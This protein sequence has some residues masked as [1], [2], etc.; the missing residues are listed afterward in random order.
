[1]SPT[2]RLKHLIRDIRPSLV[3]RL[4]Q[5]CLAR[6]QAFARLCALIAA[7]ATFLI[8]PATFALPSDP[9]QAINIESDRVQRNDKTGLTVY[10]GTVHMIQGSMN[11]KAD[12]VTLHTT[13]N[14]V[15]KII[16]IGK[17]A[18]YQQQPELD[19]GLVV[20]RASTIEYHLDRDVINLIKDASLDRE[21]STLTGDIINYDLKAELIEARGDD[22]GKRRIQMVIPPSQQRNPS[23]QQSQN[24]AP[25]TPRGN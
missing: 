15:S 14:K 13:N 21:G 24:P 25:E 5:P 8:T 11:I 6:F 3:S 20:A 16:C 22:T 18:H 19:G 12:K 10:E 23:A 17:P 1:M 2:R 9:E 7:L 4:T